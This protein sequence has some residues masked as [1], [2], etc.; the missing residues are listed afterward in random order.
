MLDEIH[1]EKSKREGE[2]RRL[3]KPIFFASQPRFIHCA[4][5]SL[6]RHDARLFWT[7]QLGLLIMPFPDGQCKTELT[8]RDDGALTAIKVKNQICIHGHRDQQAHR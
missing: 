7:N 1:E 4:L 2:R 8:T 5:F 6:F 3:K